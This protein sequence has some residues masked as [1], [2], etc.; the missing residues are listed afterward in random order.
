MGKDQTVSTPSMSKAG[1]RD[2]MCTAKWT[3]VAEDGRYDSFHVSD[4]NDNYTLTIGTFT[5]TTKTG[6]SMIREHN[7]MPWSTY[8][9]DND[10]AEGNCAEIYH[11]AWWYN[12]CQTSNLNGPYRSNGYVGSDEK[13][14]TWES[15]TENHESLMKVNMK[16]R[17]LSAALPKPKDCWDH[18][19]NG[20]RSNGIYTI[21]L[22]GKTVGVDVYC[23]MDSNVAGGGWTRIQ[24]R[25]SG[26][27]DF[28]RNWTEYKTG[29]GNLNGEFW[30][31]LE[32]IHLLTSQDDYQLRVW[33]SYYGWTY[34]MYDSF[35]VSDENS[36]Y[37]LTI[38]TFTGG[39]ETGDSMIEHNGM[40]WSTYDNDNDNAEG[41]CAE[42]YHGAWW[43]N[44]C[45]TSNL[46][47]PYRRYRNLGSDE[48]G[49]TWE[50]WAGNDKSL[51]KVEM[52]VK[53]LSAG[54]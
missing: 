9:N 44:D 42:I 28:Y 19:Q 29:F 53:P 51:I 40:P 7:G 34:A 46:N 8:D 48:K 25:E 33:L 13:G 26:N 12:D 50:N 16:I 23:Y 32:N 17:P 15:W 10:N 39:A 49:V 38:N 11:G 18:F 36:N 52:N 3:T 24:R 1:R 5:G 31:G 43:Y 41:N 45:Q 6:D 2:L 54:N 30:L 4:E 37:T 47:G 27:V 14:I 20:Q 22:K 35:H 21:F